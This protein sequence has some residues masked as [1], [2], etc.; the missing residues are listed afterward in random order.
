MS[1]NAKMMMLINNGDYVFD[2]A[3]LSYVHYKDKTKLT[4]QTKDLDK[5]FENI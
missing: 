5:I 4:K 2:P 3:K 1:P